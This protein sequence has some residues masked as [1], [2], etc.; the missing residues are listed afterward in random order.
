VVAAL[1][2]VAWSAWAGAAEAQVPGLPA[3]PI[4]DP[5]RSAVPQ[6][7]GGAAVP[8]PV[9]GGPAPPRNPFMAP[10]P[11]NNIHDDPYMS[12]TY[13]LSG[14]LGDGPEVS[15]LNA[16]PRECGSITFDSAGRIVTVCVGLD[17]PVLALL[18]PHTLQ[19]LA[20]KPLP[21]RNV[22]PGGNPFTDFSGGGYFYLD[23]RDR[24]VVPTTDRHILVVSITSGPGFQVD[25]DY[26]LSGRIPQG[27]G[28]V[29]VLPDWDG[30]LWF[31][32]R[33]G[34]VGTIDRGNGTLKT[35]RLS[36]E[37][38]SNSFA[39]DEN[40][41]VYIVSDKALYRFDAGPN[42]GP[43]VSWRVVYPNSGV[44][45][46]GQSDAGSGTT[47][48]LMG[49]SW[50]AITDNADPMNVVVY[51]RA[52][53]LKGPKKTKKR[54]RSARRRAKAKWKAKARK[55]CSAPVFGKGASATDNS[56]IGTNRSLIVE[57][58]YGYQISLGNLS[59][60]VTAPGLTRID[61]VKKKPKKRGKARKGK[62]RKR[63]AKFRC[64]QVW[65]S[66]ERAP[67]VVPKLSLAN[68]LVYTYT[69]EPR[70]DGIDAWY[71]TAL[72]FRTGRTVY[73]RL[74][75]TGFGFNNNYAPVTLGPDSTAYVGVLGGVVALP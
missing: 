42:G 59:G 41:G 36:G 75:G 22:S 43:Q 56:L 31:V 67:S 13:R 25:A 57:N 50:V 68:G 64:R 69:H 10:N 14:P 6:F 40:R 27:E 45:K 72:D 17:R 51:R 24:A 73:R 9:D 1:M 34:M 5:D 21:L 4:P 11:H 33:G 32:T 52:I 37:G 12:D 48:T 71:L 54:G 49:S 60:G 47:P 30:L 61:V 20:A 28:I 29:S 2:V 44:H 7:D 15:S 70:A 35:M 62:K 53:K 66:S 38:I 8:N 16:P 46:P 18:D 23:Q 74:A 39:V 63:P 58:N 19:T 26:D 3:V 65:V 55:V